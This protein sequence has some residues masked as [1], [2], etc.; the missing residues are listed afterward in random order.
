MCLPSTTASSSC[1]IK[2]DP[3]RAGAF[4]CLYE[5]SFACAVAVDQ[6]PS[7]PMSCMIIGGTNAATKSFDLGH[8]L[9]KLTVCW[10]LQS[11]TCL[12]TNEEDAYD[13]D[14]V[15]VK[16][17]LDCWNDTDHK[18]TSPVQPT[19][20]PPQQE[21]KPALFTGSFLLV[22]D[23][24]HRNTCGS[25]YASTSSTVH[26]DSFTYRPLPHASGTRFNSNGNNTINTAVASKPGES[27][28]MAKQQPGEKTMILMEGSPFDMAAAMATPCS[29]AEKK[30][31]TASF[32]SGKK[33]GEASLCQIKIYESIMEP[34]TGLSFGLQHRDQPVVKFH[35]SSI[36][37]YVKRLILE[38]EPNQ[39]QGG[40]TFQVYDFVRVVQL[41]SESIVAHLESLLTEATTSDDTLTVL[42]VAEALA[43]T[44]TTLSSMVQTTAGQFFQQAA[45]RVSVASSLQQLHPH[46]QQVRATVQ[47]HRQ[48][49]HAAVA[50]LHNQGQRLL[51]ASSSSSSANLVD[52]RKFFH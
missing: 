20:P 5:G 38:Q 31:E 22:N 40:I 14:D 26:P 13:D 16:Q 17:G 42:D 11:R 3:Q 46:G 43:T 24:D 36:L 25:S 45:S 37:P 2:Y 47:E 12:D 41:Q 27:L 32:T 19:A 34:K 23:D 21:R 18:T 39:Q 9:N 29:S 10:K 6:E 51:W 1:P 49:V 7:H 44:T 4:Q 8:F 52:L 50:E 48:Q 15:N 30:G 28:M 35:G 33:K